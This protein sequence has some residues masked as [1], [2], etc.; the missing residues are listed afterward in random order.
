MPIKAVDQDI[1]IIVGPLIDDTD[2]K[3]REESIVYNQSGMDVQVLRENAA[4]TVTTRC[5]THFANEVIRHY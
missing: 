5:R 3:S 2:F 4:G 1:T